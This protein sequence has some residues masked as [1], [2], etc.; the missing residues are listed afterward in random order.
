[1]RP[2]RSWGLPVRVSMDGTA[3]SREKKGS[4]QSFGVAGK[5]EPY[6]CLM[7]AHSAPKELGGTS[8]KGSA[9]YIA[10]SRY[11]VRFCPPA[12]SVRLHLSG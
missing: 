11:N 9:C 8:G 3:K 7:I 1:M 12:S 2:P 4:H 10:L 5:N 6:A